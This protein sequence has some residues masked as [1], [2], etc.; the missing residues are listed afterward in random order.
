MK[1]HFPIYLSFFL[2]FI[3]N[4]SLGQNIVINEIM[5]NNENI[6]SDEDGDFSDWSADLEDAPSNRKSLNIEWVGN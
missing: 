5:S 3:A 4:L 2:L 1:N 6:I